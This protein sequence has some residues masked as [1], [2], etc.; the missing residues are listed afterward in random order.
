M[1]VSTPASFLFSE[2]GE[3]NFIR[4]QIVIGRPG[5]MQG[6]GRRRPDSRTAGKGGGFQSRTLS[7]YA[8]T[9]GNIEAVIL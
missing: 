9:I 8:I 6:V 5:D 7:P 4:M 1:C 3:S 2:Q